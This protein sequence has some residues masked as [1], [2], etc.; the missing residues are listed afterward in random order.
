MSWYEKSAEKGYAPAMNNIAAIYEKDKNYKTAA[1]W[2]KKASDKD[3]AA[4]S[5]NLGLMYEKGLGVEK[6]KEQAKFY[7]KRA[8]DKN[9]DK[10]KKALA[11]LK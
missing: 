8:A 3:N 11:R 7:Y 1:D 10:A 6:N 5:Y 4:A 9:F 2:F